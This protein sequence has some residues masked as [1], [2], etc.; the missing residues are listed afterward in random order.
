[1]RHNKFRQVLMAL[2]SSAALCALSSAMPVQ[3]QVAGNP[4]DLH[5][6]T[7][8]TKGYMTTPPTAGGPTGAASAGPFAPLAAI[9]NSLSGAGAVPSTG[10][11]G[12]VSAGAPAPGGCRSWQDFNGRYMTS[13]SP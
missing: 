7:T 4:G 3:A 2:L 1:M 13:C 9:A 6:P 12:T 11:A 10:V 8:Y 5:T